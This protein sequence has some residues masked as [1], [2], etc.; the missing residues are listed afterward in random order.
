MWAGTTGFPSAVSATTAE[1]PNTHSPTFQTMLPKALKPHQGHSATNGS[2][3]LI[4]YA[5]ST[6]VSSCSTDM[7]WDLCL[8]Y[9]NQYKFRCFMHQMTQTPQDNVQIVS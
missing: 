5:V 2:I 4:D 3:I 1:L 9:N 6:P 8:Q 7:C